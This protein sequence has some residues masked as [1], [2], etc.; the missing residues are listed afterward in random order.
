[1]AG[2]VHG[3]GRVEGGGGQ[4][5]I[6]LEGAAELRG[7][8]AVLADGQHPVVV[9]GRHDIDDIDVLSARVT[10]KDVIGYRVG[11]RLAESLGVDLPG[12]TRPRLEGQQSAAGADRP[13]G[14]PDDPLEDVLV[15][16]VG[17]EVGDH[18]L[19]L[20]EAHF[21]QLGADLEVLDPRRLLIDRLP[22]HPEEAGIVATELALF[23]GDLRCRDAEEHRDQL[24]LSRRERAVLRIGREPVDEPLP[25][26]P[27]GGPDLG[28][29]VASDRNQGVGTVG[30]GQDCTRRA[31]GL[32]A[33]GDLR[34]LN[35]D[36]CRTALA[37]ARGRVQSD[38]GLFEQSPELV[39]GAPRRDVVEFLDPAS[40]TGPQQD[41]RDF[42]CRQPLRQG[43]HQHIRVE[44]GNVVFRHR[45]GTRRH[46]GKIGFLGSLL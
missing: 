29:L 41:I 22:A 2:I 32:N 20:F 8:Q 42:V 31:K 24:V 7:E 40:F 38:L 33:R 16:L 37:G 11:L 13:Q 18:R 4:P 21:E 45:A 44:P 46:P 34:V 15:A 17:G 6:G 36:G 39:V 26:G 1:M 25:D 12:A 43:V 19:Q 9:T 27:L 23:L 14:G 28:Q 35:P 5:G 10:S 30:G 3:V